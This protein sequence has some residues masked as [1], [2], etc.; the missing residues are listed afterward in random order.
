MNSV[1]SV[2]CVMLSALTLLRRMRRLE[3]GRSYGEV[4]GWVDGLE[5]TFGSVSQ[6]L[7][8]EEDARRGTVEAF[9]VEEGGGH[10]LGGNSCVCLLYRSRNR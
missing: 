5:C 1:A 3:G 6:S 2:D 10:G 7:H 9:C 8:G 4:L